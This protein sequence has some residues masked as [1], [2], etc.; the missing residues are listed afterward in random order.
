MQAI[1]PRVDL[2]QMLCELGGKLFPHN[3]QRTDRLVDKVSERLREEE[4]K[5]VPRSSGGRAGGAYRR[6]RARRQERIK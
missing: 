5:L 1:Q 2:E 3:P 6:C 4:L